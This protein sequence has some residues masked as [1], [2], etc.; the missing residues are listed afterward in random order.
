[1]YILNKKKG[2]KVSLLHQLRREVS[3]SSVEVRRSFSPGPGE[4]TVLLAE[5]TAAGKEGE[6]EP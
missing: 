3:T 2:A 6:K 4:M 1:M 5:G